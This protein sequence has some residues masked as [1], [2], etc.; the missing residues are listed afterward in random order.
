MNIYYILAGLLAGVSMGV[1]GVGAGLISIP[2]LIFGGMSIREAVGCSLVM[3]LLPQSL[4]GVL[5]YH[6]KKYID[7]Y[8][9]LIVVFASFI[10][11]TIGAVLVGNDYI[12]EES[13]YK[14]LT[15]GMIFITL[16]LVNDHLIKFF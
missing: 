14:V 11:I 7:W 10:G 6:N 9:S 13:T 8:A 15:I 1:I 16:K 2:I 3:Q 4:P 12:T 5:I